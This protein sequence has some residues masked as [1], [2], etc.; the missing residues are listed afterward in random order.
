MAY[1]VRMPKLGLEMERG[2]LLEW[3]VAEGGECEEGDPVAEIESEKTTAE[4][5]AREGG[6]LRAT[7]LEEG[8]E[9]E[10]GTPIGIIAGADEDVSDLETQV[11]ADL[12]DG[13]VAEGGEPASEEATTEAD[14][15]AP[16]SA[17]KHAGN[18]ASESATG[19]EEVRASP[20]ARKRAEE[21]GVD[22][23]S[24]EGTG[25]Q[26]SITAEDVAAAAESTGDAAEV[27]ASPR[28][29]KRADELGVDLAS[30]EATGPQGS[31]TEEDVEAAAESADEPVTETPAGLTLREERPFDGMR[32]TIA[33]RLGESYREAVHVTAHRTIDA[34]ELVAAREAASEALSADLSLTDLLLV[35]LSDALDDHPEFNAHFEDGSHRLYEEHNICL[36]VDV[37][38]GLIAP[39]VRDV[40]STPLPELADAR[41]D[42]TERVLDGDYTMDDLSGGTFTV[43]NLGVLGVESFDPVIN[44]PQV[45]ILGVDAL[46]RRPV[47]TESGVSVRRV[48]PVDLSFD[49]RVVDGADAARFLGS[50]KEAAED[51]WSLLPEAVE[52]VPAGEALDLP[53]RDVTARMRDDTAGTVGV[54]PVEWDFDVPEDLGGG[55]TGPTPVDMFLGSLGACLS[56][57]LRM[58]ADRS[59][60]PL[61]DVDVRVRGSPERGWLEE[62]AVTV[63]L[64]SSA[65]DAALDR[66]VELGERNC[67]VT[68]ALAD[69]VPLEISWRRA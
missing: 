48:L 21:L 8:E 58:Q 69:D 12:G 61:S 13:D 14:E 18:G 9:V 62:V 41:R 10:P 36:A 23:T 33:R 50:L 47:A 53:E 66:L 37:E 25:P 32:R 60:T 59:D 31:V 67:Y 6:V 39:V 4:V 44:P 45:A 26:E 52:R 19:V 34:E 22:L 30:V 2:V 56:L 27:K 15:S 55:A 24:V 51:P 68:A 17:V 49:H 65:D 43:S 28:A 64:E 29:R 5:D 11:R 40:D 16:K 57:S 35:A 42:L 46:Q 38:A 54:G 7:Y 63:T 20:R 3:Y 1:I